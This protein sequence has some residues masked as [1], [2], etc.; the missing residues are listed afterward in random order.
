MVLAEQWSIF[1]HLHHSSVGMTKTSETHR[2]VIAALVSAKATDTQQRI[3]VLAA[4][5]ATRGVTVVASVIQRR[6][7]SR[8]SSPGGAKRLDSPMSAATFIGPGKVDEL[9]RVVHEHEATLVY[10]LNHLSLSQS[11]RLASL[12]ACRIVVCTDPTSPAVPK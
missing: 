12:T 5:L 1:G 11:E 6:G 7:I 10:F 4:A 9:V 2:A 8:A 3:A